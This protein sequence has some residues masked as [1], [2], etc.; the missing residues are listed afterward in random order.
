[1]ETASAA[2]HQVPVC[3]VVV[4]EPSGDRRETTETIKRRDNP[5]WVT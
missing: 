2:V 3:P 5:I 1:M 4:G